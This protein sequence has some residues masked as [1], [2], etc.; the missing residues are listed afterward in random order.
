MTS[1]NKITLINYDTSIYGVGILR[2]SV[3]VTQNG[4][5]GSATF[6]IPLN[7]PPSGGS[8]TATPM[9]GVALTTN[10][11]FSA[12]GWTDTDIPLKYQFFY[13]IKGVTTALT[14]SQS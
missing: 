3:Q 11:L 5:N 2:I 10:F 8:L 12:P 13:S 4:Q 14:I 7:P 9:N 1:F 6:I